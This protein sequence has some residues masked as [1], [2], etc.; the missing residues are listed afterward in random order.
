MNRKGEVTSCF[1]RFHEMVMSQINSK[2]NLCKVI[3]EWRVNKVFSKFISVITELF[4]KQAVLIHHLRLELQNGRINIILEVSVADVYIHVPKAY[5]IDA[6]LSTT[7]LI[8]RIL[9][10]ALDLKTPTELLQGTSFYVVPPKVFGCTC[11]IRD[12]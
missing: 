6:V 12:H 7:Y 2:Q 5:Q 3:T 11:L 1:K 9:L 8:N 10:K 4:T